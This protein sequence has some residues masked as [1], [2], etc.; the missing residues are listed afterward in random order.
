MGLKNSRKGLPEK[1]AFYKIN[2]TA[3]DDDWKVKLHSG[4]FCSLFLVQSHCPSF[5][6]ILIM[7]HYFWKCPNIFKGDG[8]LS[9]VL[10]FLGRTLGLSVCVNGITFCI[11]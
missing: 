4:V 6:F 2:C 5:P 1:I 10:K 7:S 9:P 8:T 11:L 3:K